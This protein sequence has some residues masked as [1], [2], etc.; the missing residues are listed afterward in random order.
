MESDATSVKNVEPKDWKNGRPLAARGLQIK[1]RKPRFDTLTM[2]T[3]APRNPV[4]ELKF[5]RHG[6]PLSYRLLVTSGSE[7]IDGPILDALAGWTAAGK[8]LEKLQPGQTVM[9]RLRLVLRGE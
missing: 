7:R 8:P 3:T 5:D 1:T 4:V 6:K 2:I 9:V